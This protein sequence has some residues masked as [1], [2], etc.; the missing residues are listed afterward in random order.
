MNSRFIDTE[1]RFAGYWP[2]IFAVFLL[3]TVFAFVLYLYPFLT[4]LPNL[5]NYIE[6]AFTTFEFSVINA[7]IYVKPVNGFFNISI[8]LVIHNPNT[9]PINIS[10]ISVDF[11]DVCGWYIF[12]THRCLTTIFAK[13]S[14]PPNTTTTI[15]TY[16][17]RKYIP[18]TGLTYIEVSAY[19]GDVKP[20]L[21]V[22]ASSI[23]K[24]VVK[25][26]G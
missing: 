8:V 17:I 25:D 15:T 9:F 2:Y 10:T 1:G 14:I 22:K 3:I 7:S 12:P 21:Y 11:G 23:A 4:E 20:L 6:K 16:T 19:R 18:L 26:G 24:V 5:P 13:G